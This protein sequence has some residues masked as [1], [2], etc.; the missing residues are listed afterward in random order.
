M[1]NIKI[2][3]SERRVAPF[4]STQV[5]AAALP[6][7]QIGAMV[8]KGITELLKPI[9]DAKKKTKKTQDTNDVRALLLETN[10]LI[11][12][13]ADK[14]KNSSNVADVKTFFEN[15]KLDTGANINVLTN[16]ES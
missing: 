10:K 16:N 4:E 5:S 7:F 1:A 11:V 9:E 2:Q 12:L 15:T 3:R 8:E 14:H 13:E 6:V